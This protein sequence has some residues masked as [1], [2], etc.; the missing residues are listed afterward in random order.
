MAYDALAESVAL[1]QSPNLKP[2][3]RLSRRRRFAAMAVDVAGDIA[4]TM[5]ARRGAGCVSEE[6]HVL[7]LRHGRWYML[8]GGGGNGDDDLLANRPRV[9]PANQS[10][11]PNILAEL[12]HRRCSRAGQ[13][14]SSTI[15]A[16]RAGGRGAVGG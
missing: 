12:I 15:A 1:I 5:F 14:A 4:L 3:T 7:A 8:G 11:T 10:A 9:L 16:G 6:I 13:A 2:V